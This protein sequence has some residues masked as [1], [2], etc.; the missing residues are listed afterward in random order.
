MSAPRCQRP[1]LQC[2]RSRLC[3]LPRTR[4][5]R[6]LGPSQEGHPQGLVT[7][8]ARVSAPRC[9]RP[10]LQCA[11]LGSASCL[12]HAVVIDGSLADFG[13]SLFGVGVPL[14]FLAFPP[15]TR[16]GQVRASSGSTRFL[17]LCSLSCHGPSFAALF[18]RWVL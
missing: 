7:R 8:S 4:C 14:G 13:S 2:A 15:G 1:L 9:Q 11:R 5:R 17:R 3:L 16:G 10:L 6:Q 12:S 18:F